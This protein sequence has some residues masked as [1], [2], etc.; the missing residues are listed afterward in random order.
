MEAGARTLGFQLRRLEVRTSGDLE[1]AFA[2]AVKERVAAIV[3]VAS[4]LFHAEKQQLVSL[5]AKHHLPTVYENR[6]FVEAGGLMSYG[7]DVAEVFR[8]AATHV[9]RILKGTRPAD[10]PVEQPAKFD[11]VI[12]QRTARTLGLTIP[13]ALLLQADRLIE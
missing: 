8:R 3:P 6:A 10:L 5:A 7:P 13:N 1:G 9:D 2:A 12:N 11:L 4:A